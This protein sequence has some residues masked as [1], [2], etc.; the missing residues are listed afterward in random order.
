M[1]WAEIEVCGRRNVAQQRAFDL[2]LA[3]KLP[4]GTDDHAP[5]SER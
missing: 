5:Q 4:K 1:K 2:W 3:E